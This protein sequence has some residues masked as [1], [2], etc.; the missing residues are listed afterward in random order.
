ME[1][2]QLTN[3]KELVSRKSKLEKS[4]NLNTADYKENEQNINNLLTNLSKSD[5]KYFKHICNQDYKNYVNF[6]NSDI[7]DA[8]RQKMDE[9]LSTVLACS[10]LLN[11]KLIKN[12]HD[13]EPGR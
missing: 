6:H 5:V 7:K 11:Q 3:L 1:S 13:I 8:Q 10:T 12:R 4:N 9:K 2:K